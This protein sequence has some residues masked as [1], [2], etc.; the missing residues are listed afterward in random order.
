MQLIENI[1]DYIENWLS[2]DILKKIVLAVKYLKRINDTLSWFITVCVVSSL[3]IVHCTLYIF[4]WSWSFEYFQLFK[5]KRHRNHN[6]NTC[7][8]FVA[9]WRTGNLSVKFTIPSFQ[10]LPLT[11]WHIA[12]KILILKCILMLDFLYSW[13]LADKLSV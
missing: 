13:H 2:F 10:L 4:F 3:Y 8:W 12:G 9:F 11:S 7:M 5:K 1:I 6:H